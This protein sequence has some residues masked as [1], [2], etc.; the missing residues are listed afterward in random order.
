[1]AE[2]ALRYLLTSWPG[3][4]ILRAGFPAGTPVAEKDGWVS[5]MRGGA[6]LAYLPSG[7][8]VVVVLTYRPRID[9]AASKRLGVQVAR[10]VAR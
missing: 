3:E 2:H 10:L 7:P 1:M 9:A 4:S 8:K 6:A 5:D